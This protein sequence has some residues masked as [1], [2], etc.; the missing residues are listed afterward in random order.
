M[1]LTKRE[2]VLLVLLILIALTFIE[3]KFVITPGLNRYYSLVEQNNALDVKIDEIQMNL[4]AAPNNQKKIDA[5]LVSIEDMSSNYLP[6]IKVDQLLVFTQELMQ[7]NGFLPTS[8]IISPVQISM[9]TPSTINLTELVYQIKTL[10]NQFALFNEEIENPDA[11]VPVPD[12]IPAETE[13][14][15]DDQ[16]EHFAMSISATATYDQILQFLE[17]LHSYQKSIL[18]SA[19]T[20]SPMIGNT[21]AI[22][23]TLNYYGIEKLVETTSLND[24]VFV[25]WTRAPY[26]SHESDPF[27]YPISTDVSGE[28]TE[29]TTKTGDSTESTEETP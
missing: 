1:R 2:I 4:A 29:E 6:A 14:L 26:I 9:V 21:L 28:T 24:T 5:N 25:D 16:L 7:R 11:V 12:E 23:F 17:N 22:E 20:M 27:V 18:I 19:F 10:S 8:Y 13:T 3:F 15:T